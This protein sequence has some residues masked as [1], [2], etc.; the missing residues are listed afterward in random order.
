MKATLTPEFKLHI[1]PWNKEF[2][3]YS[4][5]SRIR[6]MG[7]LKVGD[8]RY[9]VIQ[10]EYRT[11]WQDNLYGYESRILIGT[12]VSK[13]EEFALFRDD[14]PVPDLWCS[15][16]WFKDSYAFQG[17]VTIPSYM[18]NRYFGRVKDLAPCDGCDSFFALF[19]EE[20]GTPYK[21]IFRAYHEPSFYAAVMDALVM[22]G[23]LEV[24]FILY[25]TEL[26]APAREEYKKEI[27]ACAMRPE[28]I[29]SIL[30]RHG[31]EGLQASFA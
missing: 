24:S 26:K 14:T 4:S 9:I 2:A 27:I 18:Q 29:S 8:E 15:H 11:N 30:E 23:G 17:A 25:S 21:T 31:F 13:D 16:C 1:G 28:R 20:A 5:T 10:L 22:Y 3:H 6:T 12:L 19:G 7:T